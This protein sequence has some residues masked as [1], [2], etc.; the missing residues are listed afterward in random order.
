VLQIRLVL[1]GGFLGAGK[2]SLL[3]A[4][5]TRLRTA[6][7]RVGVIT[8]DQGGELVDTRLVEAAGFDAEEVTGGCFCCRFTDFVQS[9]E[10]L[11]AIGPDVILAEPVGSCADLSATIL[12]PIKRFYDDRFRLAPLTV[13]VDPARAE[14][15]LGTQAD[16]NLSY[17]FRKQLAEADLVRFS[18]ADRHTQFPALPGVTARPLSAHT[19]EGVGEWMDE[20][21]QDTAAAGSRLLE[22]DYQ[23]YAEAEA[24]LGW[25]NWQADVRLRRPLTPASL[26]GPLLD[27]LDRSLT[28]EGVAIAHLKIFAQCGAGYVRAGICRN[29]EEPSVDGALDAPPASR[30]ELVL[31]LRA[32]AA[33]GTL[34]A[35]VDEAA[36]ELPGKVRVLYRQS[37]RPAPPKPEH[38]FSE[39]V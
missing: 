3:L 5:A 32:G 36:G 13:L 39:I 25:L 35:A 6:G 37:F 15:L 24:S 12:Q 22:I 33:P 29:G 10:R 7:R 16:A 2:T 26:V 34:D 18:K 1:V 11:L 23:R 28:R 38:R 17:L 19:G 30:H 4:A 8:N 21:L 27:H 31:N 20:V 9:A 14:E